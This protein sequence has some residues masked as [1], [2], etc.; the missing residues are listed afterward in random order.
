[1]GKFGKGGIKKSFWKGFRVIPGK[2]GSISPPKPIWI[3]PKVSWEPIIPTLGKEQKNLK[4]EVIKGLGKP[5]L[6]QYPRFP[7]K[8]A[9]TLIR[10]VPSLAPNNGGE[11]N[12]PNWPGPNTK[13]ELKLEWV[14]RPVNNKNAKWTPGNPLKEGRVSLSGYLKKLYRGMS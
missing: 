9:Q 11:P 1:M 3:K 7:P 6:S 5:V 13:P 14:K 12:G 4:R 10:P 8:W 2:E